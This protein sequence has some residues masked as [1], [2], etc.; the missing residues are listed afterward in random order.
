MFVFI[1]YNKIPLY[2]IRLEVIKTYDFKG[3]VKYLKHIIRTVVMV[4]VIISLI[5]C[6]SNKINESKL[7]EFKEEIK[8]KDAA[9]QN[10]NEEIKVLKEDIS[11]KDETIKDLQDDIVAL[12]K[13][14]NKIVDETIVYG[15]GRIIGPSQKRLYYLTS[16]IFNKHNITLGFD[17][18]EKAILD[19]IEN[20]NR[21]INIKRL[22]NTKYSM[23]SIDKKIGEAYGKYTW[24]HDDILFDNE[25]NDNFYI[26]GDYNHMPRKVDVII[27]SIYDGKNNA[28][29]VKYKDYDES[30]IID[31]GKLVIG[32]DREI[33]ISQLFESDLDGD[34]KIEKIVN[35]NNAIEETEEIMKNYS[36]KKD[37][38]K[39][40]A[41]VMIIDESNQNYDFIQMKSSFDIKSDKDYVNN[42]GLLYTYVKNILDVNNDNKMEVVTERPEWEGISYRISF[43]RN[44]LFLNED[45]TYLN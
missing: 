36:T 25:I 4:L 43:K 41:V 12:N 2:K 40:Y 38:E 19:L 45:Y 24:L 33:V 31:I 15:I 28:K 23:Y 9:I 21:F 6:E 10:K 8:N 30:V 5:G 32:K 3:E 35:F 13:E 20:D 11:N 17:N 27:N 7:E 29:I 22:A 44:H 14:F 18:S 16:E 42:G 39:Y 37:Y 34:G 26:S 1:I